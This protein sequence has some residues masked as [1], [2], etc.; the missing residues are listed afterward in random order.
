MGDQSVPSICVGLN[1]TMVSGGGL[2]AHGVDDAMIAHER[3]A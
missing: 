2:G 3:S 1:H